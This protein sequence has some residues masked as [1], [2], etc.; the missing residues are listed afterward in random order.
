M[1]SLRESIELLK[2]P[3]VD[4][5]YRVFARIAR[6]AEELGCKAFLI[7]SVA[8]GEALPSSDIDVLIVCRE[9]PKSMIDRGRL[10]TLI[11]DKAGLP[12]INNVHIELVTEE[13]AKY[14]LKFTNTLG[15]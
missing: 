4:D 12:P 9:L 5:V 7:G 11:E 15:S 14:Y 8:R 2:P 1:L 6:V 10:K 13:L 3:R